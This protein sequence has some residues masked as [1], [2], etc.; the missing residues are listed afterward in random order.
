[1]FVFGNVPDV[2]PDEELTRYLMFSR[3]IRADD[4]VKYEAFMPPGDLELSVTR[5][6]DASEVEI[7]EAGRDVARQSNRTLH[8]RTDL[9]TGAFVSRGLKVLKDPVIANPNHAKVT[10]WSMEKSHQMI[11]AKQIA[12]SQKRKPVPERF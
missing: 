12:A 6:R 2:G 4:T 10:S 5:L 3:W 11:V 8:G 7:W 1:M 9:S